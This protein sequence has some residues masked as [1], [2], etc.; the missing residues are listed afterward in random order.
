MDFTKD[1]TDCGAKCCKMMNLWL[2]HVEFNFKSIDGIC[3]KLKDDRCTVYS[4]R[5]IECDSNKLRHRFEITDE[6]YIGLL[7]AQCQAI[8]NVSI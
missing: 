4:D 2:K 5:P 7:E 6:E 1:C 8:K 3:E